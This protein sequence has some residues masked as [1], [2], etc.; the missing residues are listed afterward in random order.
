MAECN[1]STHHFL[2]ILQQLRLFFI[3]LNKHL[4]TRAGNLAQRV[5]SA[6]DTGHVLGLK[7]L[8]GL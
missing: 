2:K 3:S 1:L 5:I 7:F 4:Y 6:P 8:E